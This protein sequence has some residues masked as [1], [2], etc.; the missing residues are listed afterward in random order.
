MSKRESSKQ[1]TKEDASNSSD[2]EVAGTYKKA[3]VDMLKTRKI[4]KAKRGVRSDTQTGIGTSSTFGG[5][6]LV[7]SSKPLSSNP[8]GSVNLD[9]GN[10][11]GNA[12]LTYSS[13]GSHSSAST[14]SVTSAFG[15][16]VNDKS[17]SS[18]KS[19]S[20][21]GGWVNAS[22]GTDSSSANGMAGS[23]SS[24]LS[25]PAPSSGDS[26]NSNEYRKRME[27]LNASLAA[28]MKRHPKGDWKDAMQDYIKYAK[29]L[30]K[31]FDINKGPSSS[32]PEKDK[33]IVTQ[34][35]KP[36][37]EAIK[38]KPAA[39]SM[40]ASAN[41]FESKSN[42]ELN[43]SG[44]PKSFDPDNM[45]KVPEV[46]NPFAAVADTS[47][48]SNISSG[49]N[50]NT[51]SSSL[52][53][54]A[55][56]AGANS[57]PLFGLSGGPNPFASFGAP[58]GGKDTGSTLGLVGMSGNTQP[59][60]GGDDDDEGAPPEEEP[61]KVYKNDKDTSVSIEHEKECKLM[62]LSDDGTDWLDCGKGNMSIA[63]DTDTSKKRIIVRNQMGNILV[64]AYFFRQQNFE[65]HLNRAGIA[66]GV[67][68][69]AVVEVDVGGGKM[70]M[71]PRTYIVKLKTEDV[72]DTL[73]KLLAA[74]A[75]AN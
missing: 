9:G 40:T 10:T 25:A 51:A 36:K 60:T 11:F 44:P 27:K 70:E 52:V 74:V 43:F 57:A 18:L 21:F 48:N 4:V 24:T 33:P 31:K 39:A 58:P 38:P 64:N 7:S 8:F 47:T 19:A 34:I 35:S 17:T 30:E 59:Q 3:S 56:P 41:S 16:P 69:M 5:V 42:N 45:F 37:Q 75:S 67:K 73:S 23:T 50:S 6:N 46:K 72:E 71:K 54:G 1:L 32:P 63:R 55:P 68:F 62:R 12:H 13:S 26:V 61:E 53:F 28:F 15:A 2:E 49:A 20:T 66:K 22:S 14:A 29:A 65:K